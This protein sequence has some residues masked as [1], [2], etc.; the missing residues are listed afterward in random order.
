MVLMSCWIAANRLLEL[1]SALLVIPCSSAIV[2]R[3][4]EMRAC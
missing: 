1:A 3:H 2:D 4:A